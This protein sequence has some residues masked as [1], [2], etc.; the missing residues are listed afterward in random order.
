MVRT[1]P[2]TLAIGQYVNICVLISFQQTKNN[3]QRSG[4]KVNVATT[5][6]RYVCV[7][8]QDMLH[9]QRSVCLSRAINI[10]CFIM[11]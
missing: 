11:F 7:F 8:N 2:L 6:K 3:R 5:K 10:V 9:Y 4:R 1:S